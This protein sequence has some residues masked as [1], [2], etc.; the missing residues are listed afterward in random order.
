MT[1][2][3]VGSIPS[4]VKGLALGVTLGYSHAHGQSTAFLALPNMERKAATKAK[5]EKA[6][7]V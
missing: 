4:D 1:Q 2:G 7:A 3:C 6:G 5:A